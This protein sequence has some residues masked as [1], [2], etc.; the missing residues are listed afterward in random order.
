MNGANDEKAWMWTGVDRD[1][2]CTMITS[3]HFFWCVS[4][5]H[6]Q[7]DRTC[8]TEEIASLENAKEG[9]GGGGERVPEKV[10]E[11]GDY[12]E[13]QVGGIVYIKGS[14]GGVSKKRDEDEDEREKGMGMGTRG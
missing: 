12:N 3:S 14:A 9:G 5:S 4:F 11:K 2:R 13:H 1:D 10:R 8:D 6:T 7:I